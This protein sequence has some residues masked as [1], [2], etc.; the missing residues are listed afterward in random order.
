MSVLSGEQVVGFLFPGIAAIGMLSRSRLPGAGWSGAQAYL[1]WSV[2][3]RQEMTAEGT[4]DQAG[5]FRRC[6]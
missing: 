3:N 6:H 5:P 2:V 4:G 1:T